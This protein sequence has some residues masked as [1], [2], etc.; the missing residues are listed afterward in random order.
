MKDDRAPRMNECTPDEARVSLYASL[1][2]SRLWEKNMR[3]VA[4]G[5]IPRYAATGRERLERLAAFLDDVQPGRLTFTRWFG[6]GRGCAV[7]LAAAYDPWLQAQ[8]L[9][10]ERDENLRDCRPVFGE[11]K[12]WHAVTSFFDVSFDDARLLFGRAG[13]PSATQLH[14]RLVAG[15]VREYL[16]RT[17]VELVA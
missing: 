15:R 2:P 7:G 9:R 16:A 10:M 6:D 4:P 3:Y 8:G 5:N 13:Y 12:D 1:T 14:P 11:A 17:N